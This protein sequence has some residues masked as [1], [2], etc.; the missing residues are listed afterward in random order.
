MTMI[1]YIIFKDNKVLLNKSNNKYIF[2]K[3]EMD[4]EANLINIINKEFN[5]S[6]KVLDNITKDNINIYILS[7]NNIDLNNNYELIEISNLI[8]YEFDNK[9]IEILLFIIY[10]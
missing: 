5:T 1:S 4:N 9:I 10:F 3:Y 8:N 7:T 2:P 6:V